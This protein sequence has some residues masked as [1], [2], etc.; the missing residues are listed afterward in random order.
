MN[1]PWL[2]ACCLL[3]LGG[4]RSVATRQAAQQLPL[5]SSPLLAVPSM[6]RLMPDQL[7]AF[8]DDM[9]TAPLRDAAA[10]SALYYRNLPPEQSFQFGTDLFSAR[11]LAK[12][13]QAFVALLDGAKNKAEWLKELSDDFWIYQAMGTDADRTVTFSSYYE[14]TIAGRLT[15]DAVYRY[16]LYGRPADLTDVN[17]G[18][19][20]PLYQGAR[21]VGRVQGRALVPYYKR[22]DIDMKGIL[23]DRRLEIAYAKDPLDIFFLQVEGSGWLDPGDGPPVRV[24]YDGDNGWP[25]RSVG[26]YLITTQR[27]KAKGFDHEQFQ[28]YMSRHLK[29]RQ[30][31]LDYDERYVF[32]QVDQ[33]STSAFAYGNL[34]RPLTSGRS[35]ATDPRVFP[36]GALAWIHVDE[37]DPRTAKQ[38]K[39][40]G[41]S[42]L[43]ARPPKLIRFVL[44]QDEGGAIQG[45]GR[46]DFFAGHG[47]QADYFANHLWNPGKLYFLVK[48]KR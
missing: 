18:L 8:D 9:D 14:P 38:K 39:K 20:N 27:V 22:E 36:K 11:D 47:P 35:I 24:R 2:L 43:S 25:Y 31:L 48:K 21:I 7:P 32:F 4:C 46:V 12:S 42:E 30:R 26:R 37:I 6:V 19:F 28:R 34:S 29:E 16:P 44:N 13:M 1:R 23:K 45:P 10:Q 15:P 33:S 41:P 17:L 40:T 3:F 5:P